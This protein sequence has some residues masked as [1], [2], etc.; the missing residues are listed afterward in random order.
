MVHWSRAWDGQLWWSEGQ[1]SRSYEAEDIFGGLAD[2]LFSAPIG[3]VAFSIVVVVLTVF[4]VYS[5]VCE[6]YTWCYVSS[7]CR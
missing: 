5:S 1:R 3:R 2:S 4:Y 6:S 7:E